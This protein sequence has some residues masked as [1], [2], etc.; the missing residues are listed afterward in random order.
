MTKDQLLDQLSEKSGASKAVAGAVLDAFTESVTA[1]LQKG[2][3]VT[4][5]GFGTFSVS[6]RKARQGVNPATGEK[7]DIPAM[8][9][10]KFK[11]GKALKDSVK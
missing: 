2:D 7:L 6:H 5:T 4:L 11:P 3:S 10:P 1:A 9:V 8:D